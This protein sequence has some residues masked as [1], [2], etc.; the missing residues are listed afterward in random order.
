MLPARADL[1]PTCSIREMT[2][3]LR[4]ERVEP[5]GR[6]AA[7]CVA[8]VRRSIRRGARLVAALLALGA[9]S[10]SAP[11]SQAPAAAPRELPSRLTD[12][13]FWQLVNELSEPGGT[14][15][16]DNFL[17]NE[18]AFQSVIPELKATLPTG[19]AY[20][21][22]GPEQNFTYI[23]ALRP[24]LAFIVDIRR[25]NLL[26]Q[27]L[28]K[29]LIE[30][31]PTRADFVSHLFSR[32]RPN[33]VPANAPVDQ[34]FTAFEN[35]PPGDDLFR[36]NLQAVEDKLVKEHRFTLSEE[37]LKGIEYVYSAFF[38]GGIDVNYSFSPSGVTAFGGGFPTYRE[39]MSETDGQGEQR[40]YLATED[41]FRILREYEKNNAI[42]PVVGDFGGEKA[43]RAVGDYVRQHN[44]TVTAFYTSN[45]EQY[46][47]QEAYAWRR[48]LQNVATFPID[49][50]ST[51]IR[52]ISNRGFPFSQFRR[53]S[54][55]ARASTALCPMHEVVKAFNA[56]QIH[57]YEDV[58]A[59][60][61]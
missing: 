45:V 19:G 28:Y 40:G 5:S 29:A 50:K 3:V 24:K 11:F 21:G 30:M 54:P 6:V 55:G 36:D 26:E 8:P 46:L 61:K 57:R 14:F 58:V 42:V 2:M 9:V 49:S 33:D 51:F 56:G 60:S 52:S 1:I 59:M 47:F 38:R 35:V 20:L 12:R 41:N 7:G 23:V 22:V 32:K 15:R 43:L 53:I 4:R 17:S 44:A 13:A 27:L 31:S 48:F 34:L 10:S 39:L 37:D 25:G 16:S 18:N